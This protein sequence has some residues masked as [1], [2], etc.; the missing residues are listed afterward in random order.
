MLFRSYTLIALNGANDQARQMY[1]DVPASASLTATRSIIAPSVPKQYIISNNSSGGQ[2]VRIKT[3]SSTT[4]CLIPNGQT[5]L[6]VCDGTNFIEGVTAASSLLLA[7]NP[8]L[9]LQAATKQYVDAA[10]ALKLNL[11]GGT[12]TGAL[13]LPATAPTGNNAT[14][15]DYVN[16]NY[17]FKAAGG[18]T[19]TMNPYLRL[20]YTPTNAADAV[21]K[22][23]VDSAIATVT[24]GYLPLTGGTLTGALTL[25]GAPTANLQAAT[26]LYVDNIASAAASTYLPFTG[27]TLTGALTLAGA[28]VSNLQAAT[29]LYVDS[30]TSN[31]QPLDGDLTAIAALTGGSGF[32]KKTGFE[33][34]A[35]DTNSYITGNQ[36]ITLSGA[37]T[38]SGTTTI[39]TTLADSPVV[40]GSYTNANITVN[41]K[42]I[43]TSASNGSSFA[44]PTATDTTLGG[45]KVN[46]NTVSISSGTLFLNSTNVGNALGYLACRADGQN[47]TGVWD[48]QNAGSSVYLK[49][50]ANLYTAASFY[51]ASN[52]NNYVPNKIGRA[53]V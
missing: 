7:A 31:K 38:G 16:T 53:H 29:K 4:T 25:S 32:L 39:T 23:Y 34:W 20:N 49:S 11:T 30:N 46:G 13:N 12:L 24:G 52:P 47:A 3:A 37:I 6:V 43:V 5:K 8:T 45:V 14:S 44:L 33:T 1:I 48:I 21:H 36:T 35:L 51:L 22:A 19:Q 9:N 28:P 10:D 18:P 27:G 50:G 2:S 40:A 15:Y 26:K 17:L 41:A 42:G